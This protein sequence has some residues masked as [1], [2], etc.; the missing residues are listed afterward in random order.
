MEANDLIDIQFKGQ[1]YTWS[2]NNECKEV[3]SKAWDLPCDGTGAVQ[4]VGKIDRCARDLSSWSKLKFSNNRKTINSHIEELQLLQDSS[5]EDD[6]RRA[7]TLIAEMADLWDKEKCYWAQR[8]RVNWL[9]AGD[10]NTKFFHIT[11]VHRR[12]RNRILRLQSQEELWLNKE[13][14]IREEIESYFK[15]IFTCSGPRDWSDAVSA[16]KPVVT[17]EMNHNLSMPLGE[18]EIK[19]AAFEMG[20]NK[21]PGPDGFHGIFYQK[22]WGI[23][24]STINNTAKEFFATNEIL[25]D[26]NQTNIVL[27]PKVPCPEKVTQFRPISL[28]NFSY[29]ILSK[30]LANRLKSF[31]PDIVSPHQGAFVPGRQIQDNILVAHEAFHYLKLR[32]T[33]DRHELALKLDMSKAYDRVEWDFLEMVL[34]KMG[35]GHGWV[36]LLMTCVHSVSFAVTLN[37]KTGDYFSPSRGL[38]QGDPISPYLFLFISE[39]FSS[40]I[41]KA[42]EVGSLYRIK[43]SENGQTL[44]HLFFAND[45][46]FFLKATKENCEE[47]MRLIGIYCEASGQ[48]VNLEKS[49]LYSTPCTSSDIVTQ[50]CEI[51]GVPNNVNPGHYLGL[52]TIWGRSKKAS[53]SFVKARLMDKIQSWKLGTLS[54]AGLA[55][56]SNPDSFCAKIIKGI[57]YPNCS[58]LSAGKGSRASWAWSSLLE[59]KALIVEGSRWQIGN[60]CQVDIWSDRWI[61]NANPGYL[62]P[63]LPISSSRPKMVEELIDWDTNSWCLDEI[64]DLLSEEERLQIE[65]LLFGDESMPDRLIWPAT[66]NGNYSVRS[67]YHFFHSQNLKPSSTHAHSSHRVDSSVWNTI[68]KLNVTPKVKNFMWRIMV[69]A[70]PSYLNLFNRKII[71]NPLCPVCEL[72]PESIEHIFLQSHGVVCSWFASDLNYKVDL[73]AIDTFDK[74][75]EVII[76]IAGKNKHLQADCLTMVCYLCWEIWKARC[77]FVY[78]GT[79]I[80][81]SS[82]ASTASKAATEFILHSRNKNQVSQQC[83]PLQ[84]S[85]VYI[86][87][88]ARNYHGDLIDGVHT[89]CRAGSALEAEA[90]A[91]IEAC[92][93]AEKLTPFPII[94]ES[95]S[96]CLIDAINSPSNCNIWS[97]YPAVAKIK[98]SPSFR[99]R[100]VWSWISRKANST[101]DHLA[102]LTVRRMCP[103]VW[104]DRPPSSLVGILS[105]D[106]LPCPPSS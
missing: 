40:L 105:R 36:S 17:E 45:S 57:Y 14:D 30:V 25:A 61:L 31:L 96:K 28:C 21:A 16:I 20:A 8:S 100:F 4:W 33:G 91:G 26:L 79:S 2:N 6:R 87:V 103:D 35:F 7:D 98:N 94:I 55:L 82:I 24:N 86:G 69:N 43:L 27:I 10:K 97:I 106:G 53:L 92:S 77:S 42:C 67:G 47:I 3:I 63:L 85:Q 12:Q 66:K 54:M 15:N 83:E 51:L 18:E 50:F 88:V 19:A 93:L 104:I 101:A 38:R 41:Q 22:F 73:Q 56:F 89:T 72:F 64:S 48:L 95:D 37:G 59:G 60:G 11:A 52:P 32:K 68:W 62:R 84:S 65:L 76:C 13:A 49:S 81:P 90:R 46:I 78:Q 99:Q 71:Q 23:I 5:F 9:K 1:K 80:N 29:K 75:F 39:V 102:S 70:L 34:I 44:S 58:I 74:W